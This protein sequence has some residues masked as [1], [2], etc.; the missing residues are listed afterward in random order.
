MS[1]LRSSGDR[2]ILH[3]CTTPKEAWTN[4]AKWYGSQTQRARTECFR[5]MHS[6]KI[7]AGQ[8]P[9]MAS[10]ELEDLAAGMRAIGLAV[11]DP[12]L[13]ACFLDALRVAN[14]VEVR[15]LTA[16]DTRTA[17][18]LRLTRAPKSREDGAP[19]YGL[20]GG[21]GGEHAGRGERNGRDGAGGSRGSGRG[22]KDYR[23][24]SRKD[25]DSTSASGEENSESAD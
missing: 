13:Y 21:K 7:T 4:L 20:F 12:M 8:N 24:K 6:F 1:A 22:G 14:E 5:K 15:Q 18:G 19:D 16:Y 23:S 9:L 2:A 3:R 17:Y 10:G 11:D 25:D